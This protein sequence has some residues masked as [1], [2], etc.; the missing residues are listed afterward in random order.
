MKKLLA[1]ALI[2]ALCALSAQFALANSKTIRVPTPNNPAIQQAIDSA[3]AGDTVFVKTGFYNEAFHVNKSINIVGENRDSTIINLPGSG[4]IML[5]SNEVTLTGFTISSGGDGAV[6]LQGAHHCNISGNTIMNSKIAILLVDSNNNT[7]KANDLRDNE[8]GIDI[9]SSSTADP[10][11]NNTIVGNNIIRNIGGIEFRIAS[12]NTVSGNSIVNNGAAFFFY[13]M[14]KFNTVVGN[15]IA[16]NDYATAFVSSSNNTFHHNNFLNNQVIFDDPAWHTYLIPWSLNTWD[17]GLEGNFWS[18]YNG[19]GS[20]PYVIDKNNIDHFPLV[21][22][23][24]IQAYLAPDPTPSPSQTIQLTPTSTISPTPTTSPSPTLQP[25]A[26]SSPTLQPTPS[27]SPHPEDSAQ[28]SSVGLM[29]A[30]AVVVTVVVALSALVL[31]RRM[32]LGKNAN[33]R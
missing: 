12:G 2:L 3:D 22:L 23:V 7:I 30:A 10:F 6:L 5:T 19:T 28:D 17:D 29:V 25:T 16:D 8:Y 18:N 11:T 27:S 4:G 24:D 14:S 15:L 33:L 26:S 20:T 9:N 13:G 32:H 31:R 21:E 1:L